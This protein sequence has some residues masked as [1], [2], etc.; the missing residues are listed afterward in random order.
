MLL[1]WSTARMCTQRVPVAVVFQPVETMPLTV[2]GFET[3]TSCPNEYF[4]AGSLHVSVGT[5]GLL[6]P[7][8]AYKVLNT[9]IRH[10]FNT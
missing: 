5:V 1:N 6:A 9:D 2:V 4:L 3:A 8:S 10:V 7:A